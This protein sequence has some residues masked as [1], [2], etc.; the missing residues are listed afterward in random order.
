MNAL[1]TGVYSLI[2]VSVAQVCLAQ[3]GFTPVALSNQP[4]P[5]LP[6][7]VLEYVS[8]PKV[9]PDGHAAFFARLAGEGVA[10]D[11]AEAILTDR[12]GQLEVAWRSGQPAAGTT[13]TLGG[14]ISYALTPSGNLAFTSPIIESTAVVAPIGYF[15]ETAPGVLAL[16]TRETP[17]T[18]LPVLPGL[19]PVN[20]E[21]HVAWA[22]DT[23]VETSQGLRVDATTPVPGATDPFRRFSQPA[24]GASGEMVFRAFH[25]TTTNASDWRAGIFRATPAT[26][27]ALTVLARTGDPAPG[28]PAGVTFADLSGSPVISDAGLVY[29]WGR[30]QGPF[31]NNANDTG[32]FREASGALLP[33]VMSGDPVPGLDNVTFGA[34][35]NRFSI[36]PSGGVA[37]L[38]QLAN[39]PAETNT[40]IF[41]AE[42]TSPVRMIARTGQRLFSMPLGSYLTSLGEPRVGP[43]GHL[44]FTATSRAGGTSGTVLCGG[45][46]VA[47][48][49]ALVRSGGSFYVPG[50]G[51]KTVRHVQFDHETELSGHSQFAGRSF[52]VTLMFE[53]R[54]HGIFIGDFTCTNDFDGDGDAN[55]DADIEAFFACLAGNCCETCASADFDGDGDTGTEADIEAFFRVL[56]GMPC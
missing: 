35:S 4:A 11:N 44:L 9:T 31:I 8:D 56:A 5:G 45:D 37:F 42:P 39:A 51:F 6:G 15:A 3:A 34:I 49:M 46:T 41:V 23:F 12:A 7:V 20:P 30:V 40:G 17:A 19:V 48:P 52:A 26:P 28:F 18:T 14:F 16:R 43:E 55:T 53:D 32:L 25:G 1:S 24:L 38:A 33:V 10:L 54:T 13:G 29:A 21:G 50:A 27:A 2:L 22:V 36:T 47:T